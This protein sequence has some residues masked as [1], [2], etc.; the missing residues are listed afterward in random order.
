[1]AKVSGW[2]MVGAVVVICVAAIA[3]QGQTFEILASFDGTN[4]ANPFYV[5][6]VQGVDGNLY[7]T[8]YDGGNTTC[9]I[10]GH[11]FGCGTVFKLTP[12]DSLIA[13]Y[14]FCDQ[15][16]T[17]PDGVGPT[18]GLALGTDGNFYGMTM[19]GGGRNADGTI[20]KVTPGGA[21]TTLYGFPASG[22]FPYDAL[23]QGADGNFY[24]TTYL[25]GPLSYG[26]V[27][28]IT[29]KGTLTNLYYFLGGPDGANPYDGLVQGSDGSFYGTASS[30]GAFNG[31]TVF[32]VTPEGSLTTL[33]SFCAQSDCADGMNPEGGL[34][35]GQDGNF[36]GTTYGE[37]GIF[38]TVFKITPTGA[39][40]TLHT[41]NGDDGNSPTAGLVQATD[42]NFYGTTA[43]NGTS[44][45]CRIFL[46][47]CGTVFE[48]T[49]GGT[50]TT[51]HNFDGSDGSFI[52]GGLVQA[53][54]GNFYGTT[55]A[56]GAYNNNG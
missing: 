2:R 21:L 4:G 36:Y 15:Y 19:G 9:H 23:I 22:T 50:L 46:F 12:E 53:T 8:T 37:P 49:P 27:F 16:P 48:I 29:P 1:M 3:A 30:G 7:G 33:Y 26:T 32:R 45:A 43:F 38:G 35:E 31:G 5:S 10:S 14:S 51:L 25:G 18:A 34:V 41:F 44:P 17:C 40:T 47:G 56:G 54:D 52:Y 6:L 11:T 28:K 24:G 13:F 55:A 42:G 39:L 20:F